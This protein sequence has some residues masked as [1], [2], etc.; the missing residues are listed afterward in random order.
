MVYKTA[1]D[2]LV[3]GHGTVLSKEASAEQI[4]LHLQRPEQ[5]DD[6]I[7][8]LVERACSTEE[9]IYAVLRD[10]SR[11]ILLSTCWLLPP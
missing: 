5:I 6:M 3:P 2:W 7:L 8:G 1:F 4:A 9:I 11:T 10:T